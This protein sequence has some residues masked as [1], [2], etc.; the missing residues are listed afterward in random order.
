M[1]LK[2]EK[3][4]NYTHVGQSALERVHLSFLR[5]TIF[6]AKS[7]FSHKPC[8]YYS[9]PCCFSREVSYDTN[10]Y[11]LPHCFVRSLPHGWFANAARANA[12]TGIGK[13]RPCDGACR[14]QNAA[15]GNVLKITRTEHQ[16][17]HSRNHHL[18]EFLNLNNTQEPRYL[19]HQYR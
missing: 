6:P 8:F 18:R 19:R 14:R 3:T 7:S 9:I 12:L 13:R 16:L 1:G 5:Y 4:K 17:H 10:P 11:F 2:S 15:T